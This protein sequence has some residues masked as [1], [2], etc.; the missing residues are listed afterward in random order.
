MLNSILKKGF[1]FTIPAAKK[2]REVMK[3]SI[4]EK[5]PRDVIQDIWKKHHAGKEFQIARS[6]LGDQYLPLRR[7][8]Q[9]APMFIYPVKRDAGHFMMIGQM[10]DNIMVSNLFGFLCGFGCGSKSYQTIDD[11][12]TRL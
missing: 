11:P 12:F 4:V 6:L 9:E 1:S 5:E 7:N 10:Q 3:L 2:L 8:I